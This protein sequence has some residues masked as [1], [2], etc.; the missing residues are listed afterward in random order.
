[1]ESEGQQQTGRSHGHQKPDNAT[2]NG[3]QNAFR[4][5]LHDDLPGSGADGQPHRGLATTRYPASEQQVRHVGTGDQK[6]QATH[7]QKDLQAASVLLFHHR[8]TCSGRYHV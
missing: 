3:E 8:H 6:H 1:M 5:R 2:A 4:E 7:R